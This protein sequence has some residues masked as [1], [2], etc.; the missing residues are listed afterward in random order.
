[1]NYRDIARQ[2]ADCCDTAV[3]R[4]SVFAAALNVVLIGVILLQVSMR[5]FFAGGH[6]VILGELEWH[7]YA[8][9]MLFGLSYS[10]TENAHVRVDALARRWSPRRR[11]AVEIFGILFFMMPFIFVVFFH[12]LDYVSDSWRVSE[13]SDS[14]VGLP[15]RWLIK[16]VIP[17]AFLLWFVAL[18]A[19][20][21]REVV[22]LL[23]GD[24]EAR[25]N[26]KADDSGH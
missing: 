4:I 26:K 19:R 6:Q 13:R 8:V 14:P 22:F 20:L 9:A 15:Y 17:A 3:R 1:M 25:E 23:G 2:I 11:A 18:L 21:L 12:G 10:Q 7:L 24:E 5:H 16:G